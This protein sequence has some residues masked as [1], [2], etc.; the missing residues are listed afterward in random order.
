MTSKIT[1]ATYRPVAQRLSKPG[2]N[3][4]LAWAD[5][6]DGTAAIHVW[7]ML[8]WQDVKQRY[9]RSMLGPFWLTIS[10]GLL[11][12]LMGPLY[13]KLFNQDVGSYFL[14]LAV[15]FVVWQLFASYITDACGA[16]IGAEGFIKQVRLPLTVYVLRLIWKNLIIFF[17]NMLFVVLVVAYLQPPLGFDI[18][19]VPI[20]L[21]FFAINA[22]WLGIVLGLV[23]ARFRDIPVIIGNVVQ[24]FFF[25]TPVLWQ[26]GML[27]RHA[28]AVNL[29]PFYHFLEII[30]TPLIGAP[31]NR[32]SWLAVFAITMVGFAVIVPFFARYRARIAYWV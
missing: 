3:L 14:H 11:L 26:P 25:L 4:R 19:L 24:V 6:V 31:V 28:W 21:F 17:H 15:S 29:N 7:P 16:F 27:G 20:G 18:I 2:A 9:R 12:S 8:G 13:G 23:S 5:I 10:T 22:L 30:R 32:L 1:S